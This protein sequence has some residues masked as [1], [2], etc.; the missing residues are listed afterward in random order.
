MVIYMQSILYAQV[1][2]SNILPD[3]VVIKK[4]HKQQQPVN[5]EE[6]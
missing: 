1:V 5:K 4:T 2:M 6:K 3:D